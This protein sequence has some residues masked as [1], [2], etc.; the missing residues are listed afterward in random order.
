MRSVTL[1]AL[2]LFLLVITACTSSVKSQGESQV[3]KEEAKYVPVSQ[4]LYNEIQHM[5]SVM[6][7]AF[8]KQELDRLMSTF[9]E[10]LEF[11]HDLGGVT[12][13]SRTKENFGKLFENNRNTGMKRELVK[14]TLEVYPIKD[15][16]A[17]ATGKHRF[18]HL[19]NGKQDCG[20]FQ[21]VHTWQKKNGEWKVT[22]VV[23]YGH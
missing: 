11:Y 21:F 17:V 7:D 9:S 13:F 22:R 16:G 19:E 5:D 23:S 3:V 1:F 12:D 4:E 10:D 2:A 20:T 18:C 6:F 15:F 8:N 14:G